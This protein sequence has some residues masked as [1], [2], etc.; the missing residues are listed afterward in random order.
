MPPKGEST[1]IDRVTDRW[2][3]HKKH[4]FAQ[5]IVSF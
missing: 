5:N 2:K 1:L 4:N 3:V